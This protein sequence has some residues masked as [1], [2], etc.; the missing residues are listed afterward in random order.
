MRGLTQLLVF[1][2]TERPAA[3]RLGAALGVPVA[4]VQRHRFPDGELR[5]RLPP[6]LAGH[7]GLWRS[8]GRPNEKLVELLIAA[9]AARALGARELTL[10]CPY[11]AYMRQDAA[12]TPGEAVSQRHVGRWLAGLFDTVATVDPHLHRVA[13]LDEVLPG[14]RCIT[15]SA[16]GALGEHAA[17]RLGDPLLLGPD[18]ESLPWV[19]AAARAGGACRGGDA[20]LDHAVC[21][22][23]RGGDREVRVTL[24][25]A[26][27]LR[28]REVVLVDDVASTGATLRAAARLCLAQG[29]SSVDVAVVHALLSPAGSAGLHAAGV[30]GLWSTDSIVH[31]SNTIDIVP[32]LLAA[33]EAAGISRSPAA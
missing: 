17:R 7:V 4:G 24:P 18:E 30:R 32:A 20:P 25:A 3:Q 22:K 14:C 15:A 26:L 16:A 1:D 9:P 11:L 13:T 27:D 23:V 8:L 33:F 31:P 6:R 19:H 12:F 2:D 29:A 5:L 28:G 10:V 21:I